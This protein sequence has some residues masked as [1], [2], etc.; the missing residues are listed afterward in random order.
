MQK[1][2]LV[3]K[4]YFF[5]I[6]YI[7]ITKNSCCLQTCLAMAAVK[8]YLQALLLTISFTISTSFDT[9]TINQTL[10]DSNILISKQDKFALGF[11]SPAN[12]TYRYLGIWYYK[13]GPNPV[14]WVAN[15]NHG[16]NDSS[17]VL[18]V[19]RNGNLVLYSNN[20]R[21]FLLWSA[22]VSVE[23]T[24]TCVAQ[25]LDS[26]NLVLM[27]AT[28]KNIIW[29]SFDYPTDTLLPGMKLGLNRKTG[30]RRILT[31]WRS[32]DD[33]GIGKYSLE[34][35]PTGFPQAFIY[36]GNKNPIYR[37][38]PWKSSLDMDVREYRFVNNQDE[39]SLSY[40]L[41]ENNVTIICR[42]DYSGFHKHQTWHESERKWIEIWSA[43]KHQC[44]KYRHCGVNSKCN[45]TQ[46]FECECLPG[47][48]PTNPRDWNVLRDGSGGCIRKRVESYKMCTRGE[49][50]LQVEH[51]KFPDASN[52]TWFETITSREGC[53]EQ[54]KRNCSCSAFAIIDIVGKG[55]GC[56]VWFGE[57]IDTTY[58]VDSGFNL[59][60][61][62][63]A[64]ELAAFRK[65]DR[66]SG[67]KSMI[68]ILVVSIVSAWFMMIL[69]A[70]LLLKRKRKKVREKRKKRFRE[71][72][73]NSFRQIDG[74]AANEDLDIALYNLS[75]ILA[76]TDDFSPSNKLGEGGFGSVYKLGNGKVIA[77]K[78]LGENSGQG[79]EE[80]KNEVMLIGKLQHKNLVKLLGCCI[81]G[82]EVMLV[83]EYLSN[84]SLDLW[85]FDEAR[86][87]IL[88]WRQRFKIIVGTARGILYLHQDSRLRIIHRDLKTNNILLDEEM[89]PKISDFGTA[90]ISNGEQI[91]EKTT[92]VVGTFGYMSPEYVVFGRYSLKSDVYSY[93]VILLEMI[94]GK[95]NNRFCEEDPSLSLIGHVWELWKEKRALEI[96]DPSL[97]ELYVADEALRYIQI[98]L[99][100]VQEDEVDRPT[101]F[102]VVLML[103][104]DISLSSPKQPAFISSRRF[105]NS[106]Q[107]P[108]TEQNECFT[109]KMTMTTV[110]SR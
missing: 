40:Y 7:L 8:L 55:S 110:L 84:K 11:F 2:C 33:P 93:G 67:K 48:E 90:R 86:R 58:L 23:R 6:L 21:N 91:Q 53:E 61:R 107:F 46:F 28:T 74:L 60:V 51:I 79:I 87:S 9:I 1:S 103:N 43:P 101:I 30:L 54:C 15:R 29:Q 27:E 47:F 45:P 64:L 78:R 88:D 17:G 56:L 16:I 106:L 62:V 108:I 100:C 70:L 105:C 24:I 13:V 109:Y 96:V 39:L 59:N 52:A 71:T 72:F 81:E 26:G 57:L 89:N 99:L 73:G 3:G 66:F 63:D 94:A 32:A 35:N 22:N 75:T 102:N 14:V 104:S 69:F 65:S 85:L 97:K 18:S 49:G 34:L 10:N 95:K 19:N 77:V 44:D 25:L 98:G 76:A 12:S 37:A 83:Y 68:S 80:F 31:S 38:I 50:F 4:N 82:K 20:D 5:Y 36:D 41:R 92:K 42:S